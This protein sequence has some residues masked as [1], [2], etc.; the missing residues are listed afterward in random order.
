MAGFY[1]VGTHFIFLKNIKNYQKYLK[2]IKKHFSFFESFGIDIIT[3]AQSL[4]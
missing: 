3:G 4:S 2:N 1:T